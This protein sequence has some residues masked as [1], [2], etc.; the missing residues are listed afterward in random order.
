MVTT[1]IM[2]LRFADDINDED[3]S[4]SGVLKFLTQT[5]VE[6]LENNS[7]EEEG[8]NVDK[9]FLAMIKAKHFYRIQN[10][11]GTFKKVEAKNLH[12]KSQVK[13]GKTPL[14]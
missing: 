12:E 14:W 5:G 7:G 11:D 8:G 3:R 4:L 13:N 6:D 9:Q 1:A 2:H 10:P